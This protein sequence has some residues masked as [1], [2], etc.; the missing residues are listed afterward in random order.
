MNPVFSKLNYKNQ[1]E[2]VVINAPS[3]FLPTLEEMRPLA[4]V[5]TDLAQ[6]QTGGFMLA[7]VKTQQEVDTLTATLT[8]TLQGDGLL[9]FAYPKG[10]SKNHTCAFNRDTGWTELGKRGFEPVRQVAIDDDW[11][12]LRFRHLDYI[13]KMTRKVRITAP[14]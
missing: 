12:A 4:T 13:K 10:S 5:V 6:I 2:I 11:S 1:P 9:W 14:K 8:E 3:A 7:F